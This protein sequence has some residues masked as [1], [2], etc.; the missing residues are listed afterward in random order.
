MW[1]T[2][3]GCQTEPINE[4][5]MPD[6][7]VASA[8]RE[9]GG[10]DDDCCAMRGTGSCEEG[11]EYEEGQESCGW[12]QPGLEGVVSTYCRPYMMEGDAEMWMDAGLKLTAATFTTAVAMAT[13]Y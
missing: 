12:N 6:D 13:M 9:N 2:N 1:V 5:W 7:N 8:C 3:N 11:Y 4:R 10:Y